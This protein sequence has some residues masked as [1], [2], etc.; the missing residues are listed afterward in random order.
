[1]HELG[2]GAEDEGEA[3][4][5]RQRLNQLYHSGAPEIFVFLYVYVYMGS[6]CKMNFLYYGSW[7]ENFWRQSIRF[8]PGLN[9][10]SNFKK[11]IKIFQLLLVKM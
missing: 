5:P 11:F 9:T 10:K 1:M 2:G 4:S 3:G 7:P 6:Q 8:L